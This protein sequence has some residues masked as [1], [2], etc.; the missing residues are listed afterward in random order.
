MYDLNYGQVFN[1]SPVSRLAL[2]RVP[3]AKAKPASRVKVAAALVGIMLG[4]TTAAGAVSIHHKS[5]SV[6]AASADQTS[7][8]LTKVAGSRGLEDA[9]Y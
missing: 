2:H 3:V 5:A 7:S 4:A 1:G 6:G 9:L 8:S